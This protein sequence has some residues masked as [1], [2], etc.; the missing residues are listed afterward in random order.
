MVMEHLGAAGNHPENQDPL[1]QFAIAQAQR[2]LIEAGVTDPG[3]LQ[4]SALHQTQEVRAEIIHFSDESRAA[5][6]GLGYLIY[7]L[8][9]KSIKSLRDEGNRF[10]TDWHRAY[11]TLESLASG[12]SEVAINPNELFLPN[13]NNK[14]LAE[15]EALIGNFD[16]ALRTKKRIPG[17]SAILGEAPDWAEVAFTHLEV[18]GERLF[19]E[20]Y[21]YGFTRTKTRVESFS[22]LVGRF[23]ADDGLSVDDSDP[24]LRHDSLWVS[25]LV[26]PSKIR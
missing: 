22:V 17:V 12:L 16:K 4:D 23:V 18:T 1:R 24:G 10:W 11:P 15:Q 13:S 2:L 6:M 8:T 21:D 3:R 9:G 19:G 7:P 5:L 26:V 14:T 25:P 20:K